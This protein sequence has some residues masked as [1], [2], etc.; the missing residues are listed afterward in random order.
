MENKNLK[1]LILT[2]VFAGL[3]I[4]G[5]SLS[6]PILGSKCAPAQH[7]INVLSSILLGPVYALGQATI[8]A[9]LRNLTGMG[10]LFAFPGSIP[11]ALLAGFLYKKHHKNL[12]AYLGELFGT[13]IIGGLL[14][15]PIAKFIMGKGDIAIFSFVIPFF[16][17]SLGGTLL[18]VVIVETM[19]KTGV[20]ERLK[21]M[22]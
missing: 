6:F 17:S 21:K 3:A 4:I 20:L 14:S 5:S 18:A 1:K 12:L 9:I 7:L 8:A 13:S 16:V 15:Y 22:I 11:G 19:N 2:G 10:T